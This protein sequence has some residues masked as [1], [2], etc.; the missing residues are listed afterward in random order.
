MLCVSHVTHDD[1]KEKAEKLYLEFI[2]AQAIFICF[3]VGCA[4]QHVRGDDEKY[5]FEV[6]LQTGPQRNA[7]NI[8]MWQKSGVKEDVGCQKC[9]G[10]Q[11][12]RVV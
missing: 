2:I 5:I 4:G 8:V 7:Y 12:Y 3:L 10:N 6:R 9:H 1:R 11:V